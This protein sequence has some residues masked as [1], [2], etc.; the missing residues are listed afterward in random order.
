MEKLTKKRDHEQ[1]HEHDYEEEPES[2][3]TRP[4][5][6]STFRD[7]VRATSSLWVTTIKV[8][9]RSAAIFSSNRSTVE[10]E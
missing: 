1:E 8:V 2:W 7:A 6:I 10:A 9:N 4:S 5:R 3:T